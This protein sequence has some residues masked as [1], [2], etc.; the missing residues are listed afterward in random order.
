MFG[1]YMI[2]EQM[3]RGRIK[4]EGSPAL[5][6]GEPPYLQ[7]VSWELTLGPEMEIGY[8]VGTSV[9]SYWLKPGEFILGHTN[10]VVTLSDDVAAELVGKS[11]LG[12][13]GLAVHVTAGLIDPGFSGQIV[14]EMYNHSQWDIE[15]TPG[16]RICQLKFENVTGG[17]VP[18]GS[19]GLG[20]HYQ[21]Q[22]GAVGPR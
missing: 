13:K 1:S 19:E 5:L 21:D 7:P 22:R 11:T 2:E 14:L 10:E 8:G 12:R 3:E 4:I 17:C 18:Y 6:P 20:S 9:V 15:L 16:M